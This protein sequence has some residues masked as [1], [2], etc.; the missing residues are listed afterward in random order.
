MQARACGHL[1]ET[2]YVRSGVEV[3]FSQV[4]FAGMKNTCDLFWMRG[5]FVEI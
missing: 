2:R 5:F 4:R 3:R 1:S